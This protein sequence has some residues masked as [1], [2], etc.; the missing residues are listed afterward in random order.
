MTMFLLNGVTMQFSIGVCKKSQ[1]GDGRGIPQGAHGD[2]APC[3]RLAEDK[4]EVK[5]SPKWGYDW[6]DRP[7][8]A[9]Q[10]ARSVKPIQHSR[11]RNQR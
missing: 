9:L 3:R 6:G 1:T 7:D 2:S 5:S 4:H 10:F 8:W 11:S